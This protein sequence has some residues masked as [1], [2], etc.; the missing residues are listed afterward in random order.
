MDDDRLAMAGSPPDIEKL[1]VE[2][3]EDLLS[4]VLEEN[5]RLR[6]E[7]GVAR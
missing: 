3:L 5:A 1:D 7:A 2:G 6:A 4:R